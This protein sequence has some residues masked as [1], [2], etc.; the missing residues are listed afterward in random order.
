MEL[1]QDRWLIVN[2]LNVRYW[3]VGDTNKQPLVLAHGLISSV[4]YWHRVIEPLSQ[5][6]QVIA[7]DWPG[8]GKSDKPNRVYTLTFYTQF[9]ND[10]LDTLNLKQVAL[11]GHS[12][13]GGLVLDFAGNHPDKVSHIILLNSV[14][15]HKQVT[16]I[17]RLMGIPFL[18]YMLTRINR[19]LFA[20]ALR[21]NVYDDSA[22]SDEFIDTIYPMVSDPKARRTMLNILRN[23]TGLTGMKQASLAHIWRHF[24]SLKNKPFLIVWGRQDPILDYQYHRPA[25]EYYCPQAQFVTLENCG[26]I[27]QLEHNQTVVD[28]IKHFVSN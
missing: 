6:Y 17:F 26:H 15:F 21:T 13:G 25:A 7:Y 8:F 23:H 20:K 10:L 28:N 2:D 1:P 9:L 11:V 5:Y 4:E 3:H 24:D 12:L 19:D 22:I 16:W 14:G 27:P 18:G